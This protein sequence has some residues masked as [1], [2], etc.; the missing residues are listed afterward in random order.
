MVGDNE[1]VASL[2]YSPTS[3]G[4]PLSDGNIASD[5]KAVAAIVVMGLDAEAAILAG[6][7]EIP[8]PIPDEKGNCRW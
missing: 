1:G 2:H 7:G 8:E 6:I 3:I 4:N 5:A